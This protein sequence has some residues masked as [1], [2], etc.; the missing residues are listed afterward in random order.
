MARGNIGLTKVDSILDDLS[1]LHDDISRRAYEFFR[2][3]GSLAGGALAD[4]LRAERELVWSPAIELRQ[5]DGEFQL[6]AAIAGVEPKDLDVQVTA[7]DILIKATGEHQH[8][9][10]TG[11]VHVCEFKSGR[12]F[13]SVHL[14]E[15]IDPESVK[16]EYHNGLLRLTAT[17]AKVTPKRIDV[18]AA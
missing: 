15:R 16:A 13:R 10:R 7:E 17:I 12:L 4:W 11:T 2:T 6:E 5:K 18:Q 1:R 9:M 8:E 14:P 3:Q